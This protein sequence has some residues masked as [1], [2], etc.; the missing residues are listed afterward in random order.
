MADGGYGG[1]RRRWRWRWS[2]RGRVR[3]IRIGGG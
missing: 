2:I 3:R 1:E